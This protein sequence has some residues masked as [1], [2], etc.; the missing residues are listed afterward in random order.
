M[1][2]FEFQK[3]DLVRYKQ[4][5]EPSDDDTQKIYLVLGHKIQ[6]DLMI[7]F[8][9]VDKACDLQ[10]MHFVDRERYFERV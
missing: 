1:N 10:Q 3:G 9:P 2:K 4:D 5:L 8:V 6:E 7:V